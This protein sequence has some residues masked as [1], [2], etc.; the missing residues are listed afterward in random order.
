M[1]AEILKSLIQ[2]GETVAV[3]FKGEEAGSLSDRD[4]VE[5]AVCLANRSGE[6][7][8]WLLVGVEDDGRVTGARPRHESSNI[9]LLRI[10]ALVANRTRPSLSTRVEVAEVN[11]REVLVME[12]PAMRQPVGTADG[13]YLRRTIGG[14][15][16][17]S[18]VPFHFHEMQSQQAH[19]GLLDHSA[20]PLDG[21]GMDALEP[22]EFDRY[23]RSI[24]EN[25]TRGDEAL[26]DLSNIELARAL[27][28]LESRGG[29]ETVRMLGLLLFGR[30]EVLTSALPTH[31]VA[32]QEIS[33]TDVLVNDFFRGPLLRVL[34][35]LSARFQA[36][37][38]E[39][40]VLV[41]MT[42][43]GVA[44]YA[45]R[46]FREAVANALVHRDYTSLGAVHIQWR[47]DRLEVSN[48]G[49][50]PAG[51]RLDNLL[52]TAPRP[53][54]PLLADA[55]KRAGI[56]ERT[57]RGIDTIFYEQLRN[58][59][60]APSYERSTETGVTLALAGG[61]PNLG[62]VRLV[63]E[64]GW[65]VR[66][67]PLTIDLDSTVCE[68]YGLGKGGRP[69][70]W[71]HRPAGLSPAAGRR[72]GHRRRADGAAA[73]GSGQHRSGRGPLPAGDGGPGA[74]RRSHRTTHRPRRQRLLHPRHGRRLPQDGRPL[75]HHRPPAP[76]PAQPHRGHT[77]EGL[78]SHPLL[79]GR[80]CRRGRD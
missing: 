6:G 48:P 32:F 40:E 4:L 3:E 31:E 30:E 65:D 45:E 78:D 13:R 38:R 52:V 34:E 15:G 77:R 17:P 24:R 35:E 16:K 79:D 49:G 12:V 39:R 37:N 51:V 11:G 14:D 66:D 21:M 29:E 28:A 58:G 20:L 36:R 55:L 70:P 74:L 25:R 72:R 7:F 50:F 18:C 59:R 56:V 60:A 57:G 42:R 19:H 5:A 67:A 41:G 44:E 8:G 75:L 73:P 2:Q 43:V 33:G 64:G 47:A 62:L 46:A 9:N 71:L 63:A 27:G 26:L 10:Q 69:S 54:N 53:R 61:E 76:K 68:T 23:R 22:L 80:R 1:T